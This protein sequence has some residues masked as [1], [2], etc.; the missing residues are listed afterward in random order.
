MASARLMND[1]VYRICLGRPY[2]GRSVAIGV[3]VKILNFFYLRPANFV[4]SLRASLE[5]EGD[6][7]FHFR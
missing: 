5:A 4:L 1:R 6:W 3:G 7:D 2:C